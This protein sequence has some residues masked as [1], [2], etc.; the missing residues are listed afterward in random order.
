MDNWQADSAIWQFSIFNVQFSN[1]NIVAKKL[2]DNVNSLYIGA[3]NSLRPKT[4]R[5]R[6]VAYVESCVILESSPEQI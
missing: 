1:P 6:I 2:T 4:A 3:A 5:K